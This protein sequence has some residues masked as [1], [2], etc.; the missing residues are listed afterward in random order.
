MKYDKLF[1]LAKAR[2]IEEIELAFSTSKQLS[3]SLFH[4]EVDNYNSASSASYVIRG[5]Y[6]GKLGSVS[7]DV[8]SNDLVE[9]FVDEIINNAK[10]I[11]NDDPVFIYGGSEKYKKVNTFN[12][13]LADIPV[14]TK[15]AKLHELEDKIRTGDPRIIEVQAVEYEEN[16]SSHTIVNSKGL[17]LS[18]KNNYF[19]FVGVA[20]AKQ[21]EQVKSGYEFFVCPD[22]H[23][24]RHGIRRSTFH[25]HRS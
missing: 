17:K 22:Q 13:E 23:R 2:G 24:S 6:N 18:T 25:P 1:N 8:Y 12:R 16:E 14:E 11:E 4:G 3:F 15:L 19:A 20:L 9:Y 7:S 5:I 21:G 10:Y